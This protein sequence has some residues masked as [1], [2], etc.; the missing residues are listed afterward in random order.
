VSYV[1]DLVL[2]LRRSWVWVALQFVLTLLLI[3][4]GLGWTR[5]PEKNWWQVALTL[6]VP[7]L[8]AVSL[9]ELEAGT[10][11]SLADNDGKRVKL[12]WGAAVL[13]VWVALYLAL[14]ALLDWCDDRIPLWA[15][16]LNSRASAGGRATLLTYDHLQLW[17]TDIEWLLRWVVLPAKLIPFA[18]A[19]AQWG[20]RLPL[21]KIVRFLLKWQW[22]LAV[23][24][25]A[26]VGVS[27]PSHFYGGIP[28]GT[29]SH[30]V[31]MVVIK[32]SGAY[33]LAVASWT[34]LLAW[35]AVL[36]ARQSEPCESGLDLDLLK[37]LRLG[38]KWI[39]ITAGW[40]A[41]SILFD[42]VIGALPEKVG[43]SSWLFV[44]IVILL[45][46]ILLIQVMLIRSMMRQEERQVRLIW[47]VLS[48]LLWIAVAV[49][50]WILLSLWRYQIAG[51]VLGWILVPAVL[52][53]LAVGSAKWG[54]KMP[55]R[56]VLS[57]VINWRWWLGVL[58]TVGVSRVFAGLIGDSVSS[59][60]ASEKAWVTT[61]L[62]DATDL[63]AY[64]SWVALLAWAVVL[65]ERAISGNN[66]SGNDE[67][68]VLEPVGSGPLR[69]DNVKL[70]LP[71]SSDDIGGNA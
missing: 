3:L 62:N 52:I 23:A 2:R 29:V 28:T 5:I 48:A 49:S 41:T 19:S 6:L 61:A 47:G 57:L 26:A 1:N 16:Y 10:M 53:P 71:E 38:K 35:A 21:R 58:V 17:F 64:V 15:G 18:M 56:K 4:A 46:S 43:S 25:A 51:W 65:I 30:Q 34:V 14:W 59:G 67:A 44:P 68:G 45:V 11:R 27:L 66:P 40:A 54:L 12:V 33:L 50:L 70:P 13:L 69:E 31:W 60:K 9:L 42:L 63:I 24:V 55:W 32:V 22:W 8:L 36:M 7:L 39:W 37:R 20:W